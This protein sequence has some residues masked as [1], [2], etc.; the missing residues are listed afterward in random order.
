MGLGRPV[1][2]TCRVDR[3]DEVHFE[4]RQYSHIFWSDP[5]ELREQ[6]SDHVKATILRGTHLGAGST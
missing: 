4:T 3:K 5:A 1:V 2:W 6:L